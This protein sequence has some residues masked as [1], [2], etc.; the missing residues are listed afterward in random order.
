MPFL[1]GAHQ[2]KNAAVVIETVKVLANAGGSC[3]R[4]WSTPLRRELAGARFEVVAD[5]PFFVVDGGHNPQCAQTVADNL[6]ATSRHAARGAT[7]WAC[8]RTRDYMTMTDILNEAADEY[9]CVTPDSRARFLRRSLANA[10]RAS[11]KGVRRGQH[12]RRRGHG[13][14]CG[15]GAAEWCAVGFRW[16]M[17]G[18]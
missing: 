1:L 6:K 9:V 17:A 11:G 8:W 3:R 16:R 10:L 13:D 2:L 18:G 7:E 4:M 12:P 5:E 15:G 14:R